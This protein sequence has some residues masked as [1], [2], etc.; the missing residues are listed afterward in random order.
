MPTNLNLLD[1]AYLRNLDDKSVLS[2]NGVRVTDSVLASVPSIEAFRTTLRCIKKWAKVRGIYSNVLG[3]LGGVSWAIL[4]ARICQLYPNAAPATL[5][6]RFFRVYEQWQWPAPVMLCQPTDPGIVASKVWNPKV[7]LRDRS[8]LMPVITP[9]YPAMNSTYNVSHSTMAVLKAEF[10]RGTEATFSI[11]HQGQP[12]S[13]LFQPTDMFR[14]YK[15]YLRIDICALDDDSM[16]TWSGWC[17]SRLRFLIAKL[18]RVAGIQAIHPHPAAFDHPNTGADAARLPLQQTFFFGLAFHATNGKRV[19]VDLTPAV[20]AWTAQV[21]ERIDEARNAIRVTY[22]VRKKLPPIVRQRDPACA[23]FAKAKNEARARK[24]TA[25]PPAPPDEV[26]KRKRAAAALANAGIA[27]GGGSAVTSLSSS[28]T[29]SEQL[30]TVTTNATATTSAAA[31]ATTTSVSSTSATITNTAE[32]NN[33]N[34][35]DHNNASR[36][37]TTDDDL[38][39]DEAGKRV[40]R[41]ESSSASSIAANV[42]PPTIASLHQKRQHS[43]NDTVLDTATRLRRVLGVSDNQPPHNT[44]STNATTAPTKANNV[45]TDADTDAIYG[46]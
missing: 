20:S 18:E 43:Q 45:L 27:G 11:E 21:G 42:A 6:S 37:G 22:N 40:R 32:T 36:S 30:P 28:E 19:S 41:D 35:D 38:E 34:N 39:L 31:T 25:P 46:E 44:P 15:Y 17:E 2:L 14:R 26:G 4:T 1:D 24:G 8:H 7:N 12:W 29:T 33:N 3:Y 13:E 23:A 10:Q 5:V 9:A 16:K